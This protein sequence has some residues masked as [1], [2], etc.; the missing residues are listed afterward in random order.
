MQGSVKE[1]HNSNTLSEA[2]IY[3]GD[4]FIYDMG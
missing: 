4:L 3:D 2:G 1:Y